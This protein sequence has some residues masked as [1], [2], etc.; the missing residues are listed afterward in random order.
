MRQ[1]ISTTP[2]RPAAQPTATSHQHVPIP[3]VGPT[4]QAPLSPKSDFSQYLDRM[5]AAAESGDH[6]TYRGMTRTLAEQPAGQSLR[7]EASDAVDQLQ[8][9]TRRNVEQ[10]DVQR[11]LQAPVL[12]M[13]H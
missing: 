4:S 3:P 1:G 7:A 2:A 11:Q 10:Q 13:Q 9:Q 5:L 6:A 12:Q 8:E